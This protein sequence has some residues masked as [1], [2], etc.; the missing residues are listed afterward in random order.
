MAAAAI[1]WEKLSDGGIFVMIEPGTPDGFNSVRCVREML[2]ECCPPNGLGTAPSCHVIAPCTHNG[3]CPMDR[4]LNVR[5]DR[6]NVGE[7]SII[8]SKSNVNSKKGNETLNE[9]E[10]GF[11]DLFGDDDSGDWTLDEFE[12]DFDENDDDEFDDMA[13]DEKDWF[14]KE[15]QTIIVEGKIFEE[16]GNFWRNKPI[17]VA[18]ASRKGAH[19]EN[20][21]IFDDS[22]C[23]FPH[24][25][26]GGAKMG[27]KFSY[28][29][30]QKRSSKSSNKNETTKNI[31][32]LSET[33]IVSLLKDSFDNSESD[34]VLKRA[35]EIED[36]YMKLDADPLGLD[37]VQ[38]ENRQNWGKLVRAPIKKKGHIIVD[39]CTGD[40]VTGK[41]VRH[42]VGRAKAERAAPGMYTAARKARWGGY[43]PDLSKHTT[44]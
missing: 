13:D 10:Q 16:G 17:A 35:V 20:T 1:L 38:G 44:T 7:T 41:I 24:L 31:D 29:V 12:Q 19:I 37:F 27:E 15:F 5:N 9:G 18:K 3:K 40:D 6:L 26:P 32:C 22:F 2:L 23:G 33:N 39:F 34:G 25:I 43:W 30:L 14:E 8:S 42:R 21:N 36:R 11:V 4:F 28:I